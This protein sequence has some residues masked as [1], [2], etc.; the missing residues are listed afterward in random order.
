MEKKKLTLQQKLDKRTYKTPNRFY[1]WIYH[2]IMADIKLGKHNPEIIYK[3]DIRKE[4]GP[5]FIIWNHLSRLDHSFICKAT[6][7][8]RFS[9]VAEYNEFFRSHL[10]AV[11]K[12]MHILP[13]KNFCVDVKG[14]RA[15]LSIINQGG[16]VTI[17][18][19]GL[20]TVTGYNERILPG[21]GNLLKHCKVPVYLFQFRGQSLA[22]PVFSPYYRYGGKTEV[23]VSK[24]FTPERLRELKTDEIEQIIQS[25]L[26]NDDYE[27]QAEHKFKWNT[28]GK[29]CEGMHEVCYKCPDCGREFTMRGEGDDVTCSAC[30]FKIH[31][32][33]YLE[34]KPNRT[35][36]LYMPKHVSDW[37]LWERKSVIEEVRKNPDFSFTSHVKIG[38]IP[39]DHLVKNKQLSSEIVG[40]GEMTLDHEGIHYVGTRGGEPYRFDLSYKT[41]YRLV[42]NINTRVFSLYVDGEYFDFVPDQ[43]VTV[44]MDFIVQEMHRFHF[45]VWKPVEEHEYLYA[46]YKD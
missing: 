16:C 18:P 3:D 37:C 34:L 20:A 35:P 12:M 25:A 21:T 46:P 6:Y 38:N 36:A 39:T 19:E 42:E 22:A 23:T 31:Q 17:A 41:Y 44:K 32:N 13:K 10:A 9:M 14:M 8:R 33:E 11:F 40:E 28:R 2:F 26:K 29:G 5:C 27:W 1:N 4:T 24:L 30:G 7:P 43:P 15:M 45:N